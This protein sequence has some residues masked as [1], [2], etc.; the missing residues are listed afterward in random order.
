MTYA[1]SLNWEVLT[2]DE[3]QPDE[4]KHVNK[5]GLGVSSQGTDKPHTT[6]LKLTSGLYCFGTCQRSL[7][8]VTRVA[9]SDTLQLPQ[10]H[11]ILLWVFCLLFFCL[12]FL[13][14]GGVW[15]NNR[16]CCLIYP[17]EIS[18]NLI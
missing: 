16:I 15:S 3:I 13:G 2:A 17:A 8:K 9:S 6:D 4:M 18:G 11:E 12:V 1:I 14:G 10:L 7:M 5:D